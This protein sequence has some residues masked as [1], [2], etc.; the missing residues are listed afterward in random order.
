[1]KTTNTITLKLRS[2]FT[3]G[4]NLGNQIHKTRKGK[5]SYSRKTRNGSKLF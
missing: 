5:G 4:L 2:I 1:M 3:S